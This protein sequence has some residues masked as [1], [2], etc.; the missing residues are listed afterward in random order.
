MIR[1]RCQVLKASATL[2]IF[3][4]GDVHKLLPELTPVQIQKVLY[5]LCEDDEVRKVGTRPRGGTG[6][7]KPW[8]MYEVRNVDQIK[9]LS[10]KKHYKKSGRKTHK[11]MLQ[12][13]AKNIEAAVW[14]VLYRDRKIA[15]FTKLLLS[16]DIDNPDRSLL[17]GCIEDYRS[18]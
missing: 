12:R 17:L 10:K 16:M 5:N 11:E 3:T 1:I 15:L 2:D 4:A 14:S 6:E 13:P 8:N 7:G 18:V 9:D